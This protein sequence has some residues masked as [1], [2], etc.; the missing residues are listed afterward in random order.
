MC[1]S[2]E[3]RT[4]IANPPNSAQ[5][6]GNPYHSS[7]LHL[8]LSGNAVQD[9][10]TDTYRWPWPIYISPRLCLMRNVI[11][12]LNYC[13]TMRLEQCFHLGLGYNNTHLLMSLPHSNVDDA[14]IQVSGLV[15]LTNMKKFRYGCVKHRSTQWHHDD[16]KAQYSQQQCWKMG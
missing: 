2:N 11:I 3:T 4:P 13:Q 5:L 7:K 1:H 6:E 10:Q 12:S 9:R 16:N 15:M 14:T 8:G